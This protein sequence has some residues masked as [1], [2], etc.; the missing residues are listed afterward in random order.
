VIGDVWGIAATQFFLGWVAYEQRAYAHARELI[1]ES[2]AQFRTLGKPDTFPEA[3]IMYAYASLALG[4]EAIARTALEEALSLGRELQI[5]D[6]CARAHCG[7]GHLAL[8]QGELAQARDSYE[9]S[10]ALVQG[11]WLIPRLKWVLASSLEGLGEIALAEGQAAWTVRL[12][13]AG[14]AVRAAHGYYSPLFIEQPYYDR[15]LAAARAQLSETAYAAAWEEGQAMTPQELISARA[16]TQPLAGVDPGSRAK[17]LPGR[18]SAHPDG[19]TAREVE[20]L[21]L[22]AQ[23]LSNNEIAELLVLSPFTVN[24]HTQS[25]YGKLSI[26]S[27]SAATRY[28]IEH[29]L[30]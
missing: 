10:I 7:L 11:R 4:D 6:D 24:K 8:R 5:Q 12:Y 1:G 20:V 13:A 22:L 15:T 29:Q 3:L 16:E 27:R 18:A 25:I 2:L 30:L 19:L 26:K 28:A 23:G 17:P 14:D 21:R 9:E